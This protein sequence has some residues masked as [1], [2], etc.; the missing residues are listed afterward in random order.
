MFGFNK[1]PE[2]KIISQIK[3][4]L[5]KAAAKIAVD[6]L[7]RCMRFQQVPD[8]IV[9]WGDSKA[10]GLPH[11][12]GGM[13]P[14]LFEG[15]H[16][17][18]IVQINCND[19]K[20]L[21]DFPSS[22]ML[23]FFVDMPEER[24]QF[25]DG[26]G[27][28]KVLYAPDLNSKLQALPDVS[29]ADFPEEKLTPAPSFTIPDFNSHVFADTELSDEDKDHLIDLKFGTIPE[30]MGEEGLYGVGTI[31]DAN[32]VYEWSCKHLGITDTEGRVDWDR[33]NDGATG[34]ELKANVEKILGEWVTLMTYTLD[35]VGY[36]DSWLH[37]G[38]HKNDL[39]A[40]NFDRAVGA[41]VTT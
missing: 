15:R 37:V 27:Q 29:I 5:A 41:I 16:L 28:I 14:P 20:A 8:G 19:L 23:Y 22:G 1:S 25:P 31:P 4:R 26:M 24:D 33:V 13:N 17:K 39:K 10:G 11:L 6:N 32:A 3:K 34:A 7:T 12:P 36:P 18:F 38:I 21:N 35:Y 40:K 30:I 2:E 9:A